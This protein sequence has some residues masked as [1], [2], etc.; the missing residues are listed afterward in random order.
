MTWK[1]ANDYYC[2]LFGNFMTNK[3]VARQMLKKRYDRFGRQPEDGYH[4]NGIQNFSMGNQ[5]TVH[6][7]FYM[8]AQTLEKMFLSFSIFRYRNKKYVAF[9]LTSIK[10]VVFYSW[11][12]IKRYYERYYEESDV[13]IDIEDIAR[14]LLYNAALVWVPGNADH[15]FNQLGISRDGIF[16]AFAT[17]DYTLIRTYITPEMAKGDQRISHCMG[18]DHLIKYF[19]TEYNI[20]I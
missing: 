5:D 12:S 15:Y 3:R 18:T 20:A 8:H 1:E 16:L 6:V 17:D 10:S 14:M 4:Y 7:L 9:Y 11:H 19:K 2:R 13:A